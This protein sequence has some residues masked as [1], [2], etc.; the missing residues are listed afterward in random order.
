MPKS[1]NRNVRRDHVLE[2]DCSWGDDGRLLGFPTKGPGTVPQFGPQEISSLRRLRRDQG[3]NGAHLSGNQARRPSGSLGDATA[4]RSSDPPRP[5]GR[6]SLGI[7]SPCSVPM[8]KVSHRNQEFRIRVV[9]VDVGN[10]RRGSSPGP[11]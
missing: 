5:R 1:R 11:G 8:R 4:N 7:C 2:S 3:H 9:S 6:N 10:R